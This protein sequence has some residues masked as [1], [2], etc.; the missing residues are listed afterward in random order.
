MLLRVTF[1]SRANGVHVTFFSH[2]ESRHSPVL[3]LVMGDLDMRKVTAGLLATVATRAEDPSFETPGRT[4]DEWFRNM[5]KKLHSMAVHD[6]PPAFSGL[7]PNFITAATECKRALTKSFGQ[8]IADLKE[9]VRHAFS[10][11][12]GKVDDREIADMWRQAKA[13]RNGRS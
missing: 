5:Y 13:V 8:D 3:R 2:P 6:G 9:S 4:R 11:L 7:S 12:A 10:L 1:E